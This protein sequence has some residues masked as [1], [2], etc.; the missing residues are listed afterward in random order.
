[1]R[2]LLVCSVRVCTAGLDRFEHSVQCCPGPYTFPFS[3]FR[4][5]AWLSWRAWPFR[6]DVS[7]LDTAWSL[8]SGVLHS[9]TSFYLPG[10]LNLALLCQLLLSSDGRTK[11]AC[12]ARRTWTHVRELEVEVEVEVVV[13][14]VVVAGVVVVVVLLL[15]V[16]VLA[17]V[18]ETVVQ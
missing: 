1:M 11:S 14:V 7:C 18:V 9:C 8:G 15:V 6:G 2:K 3:V 10:Q 13:V 5:Y 12:R 17:T 4:L 16:V